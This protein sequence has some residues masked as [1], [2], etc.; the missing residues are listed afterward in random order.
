[1]SRASLAIGLRFLLCLGLAIAGN[2]RQLVGASQETLALLGVLRS[3]G[4]DRQLRSCDP[5]RLCYPPEAWAGNELILQASLALF[6]QALAR[7]PRS[8]GIKEHTAELA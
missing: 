2:W 6:E 5:S 3:P 4:C 8:A 7:D 1:M